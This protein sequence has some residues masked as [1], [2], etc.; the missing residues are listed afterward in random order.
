M[1][2]NY[3]E[4]VVIEM[5]VEKYENEQEARKNATSMKV[6]MQDFEKSM[7]KIKP[8]SAEQIEDYQRA[9]EGF[10][11]PNREKPRASFLS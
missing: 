10:S 11:L 7:R 8:I 4:E 2:H 6:S 9:A 1:H 5:H 3:L